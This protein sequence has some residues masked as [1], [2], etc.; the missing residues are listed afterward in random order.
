MKADGRLVGC[1]VENERV[2]FWLNQRAGSP[3]KPA[4]YEGLR[5]Y[6]APRDLNALRQRLS[7]LGFDVS[8]TVE[9]DYG[10]SEFFV[11]D[12]DGYSHCFGAATR[13]EGA[14]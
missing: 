6:W 8:K 10:Q 11:I 5:L 12:H 13:K 14:T 7:D 9:R 2:Q 4:G 1:M 3:S